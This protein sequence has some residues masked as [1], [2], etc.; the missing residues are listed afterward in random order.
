MQKILYSGLE[1]SAHRLSKAGMEALTLLQ[2]VEGRCRE[3]EQKLA[4]L[5][6]ARSRYM[7]ELKAA[8]IESKSGIKVSDLLSD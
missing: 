6:Q 2:F 3:A 1:Y 8:I 4:A 7:H 5:E